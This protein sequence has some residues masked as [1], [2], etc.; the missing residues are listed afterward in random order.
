[1]K[2]TRRSFLKIVG[3]G[4]VAIVGHKLLPDTIKFKEGGWAQGYREEFMAGFEKRES[5][6]RR[7]IINNTEILSEESAES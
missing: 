3:I 6:M 2:S 1:M 5:L 7:T 4:S